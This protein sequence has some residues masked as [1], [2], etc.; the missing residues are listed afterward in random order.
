MIRRP[1]PGAV[2]VTLLFL[3]G[4]GSRSG[5][6]APPT[7]ITAAATQTAAAASAPASAA[8]ASVTEGSMSAPMTISSP[9]FADGEA[10]PRQFSCDG[11]NV[12]PPIEWAGVPDGA[13]SLA[14][15]VRDPDAH[16][17]VHWV[18]YDMD[19][20]AT[21]GLQV[22]WSTTADAAPQ[23]ENGRGTIGW[24]GPCPPS[25][26]H[27]YEFRL[28]ALDALLNLPAGPSADDVLGAADG[29]TLGEATLN[30]TY[31]RS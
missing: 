19:P 8:P 2:I 6:Q 20:S 12:S 28:L 14:L 16:G 25:G 13:I 22:G 17:F 1:R 30:A 11:D 23:G 9:D 27:H 24:T 4:C 10:I 3:A 26:T 21:G 7:I 5:S 18:V 29:H 31:A 15:V